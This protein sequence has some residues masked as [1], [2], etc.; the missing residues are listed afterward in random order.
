MRYASHC[1]LSSALWTA[2]QFFLN[3]ACKE[4]KNIL[5]LSLKLLMQVFHSNNWHFAVLRSVIKDRKQPIT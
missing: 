1:I 2:S 4:L 3:W 5:N